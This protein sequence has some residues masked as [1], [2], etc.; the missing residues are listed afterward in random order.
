MR[1][2]TIFLH[3][4]DL[5]RVLTDECAHRKNERLERRRFHRNVAIR[6][7]D[8]FGIAIR[9]TRNVDVSPLRTRHSQTQRIEDVHFETK[10]GVRSHVVSK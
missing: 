10:T 4:M 2:M 6:A 1:G 8:P 7:F 9:E 5:A 3:Y